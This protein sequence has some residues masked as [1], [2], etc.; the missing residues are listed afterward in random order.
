MKKYIAIGLVLILVVLIFLFKFLFLP[1][2]TINPPYA[3]INNLTLELEIAD[4]FNERKQGLSN[5]ETLCKDC[6]MLFIFPD[7]QVRNFWMKDMNFPLDIIWI[8][9]DKIE[10]INEN[11]LP[12]GEVPGKTYSSILPV[13][14]VLEINAGLAN[15]Y[16]LEAGDRIELIFE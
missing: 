8:N 7:K 3:K 2:T 6:G 14:Y 10:G 5:R 13:N 11:L 15:E 4:D 16:G 9:D 1:N 12:E